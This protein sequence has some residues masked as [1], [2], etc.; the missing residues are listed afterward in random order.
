MV[1]APFVGEDPGYARGTGGGD[2]FGGRVLGG[3]DRHGDDEHVD[4]LES[5]GQ[6]GGVVVIDFDHI[7]E[8]LG[9][10]TSAVWTG[11]GCDVEFLAGYKGIGDG[12]A[13]L[14]ASLM[15]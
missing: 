10:C 2:E 1:G 6:G 11:E 9:E 4:V 3:C 5:R 13:A 15:S 14:A 8:T 7:G 12:S